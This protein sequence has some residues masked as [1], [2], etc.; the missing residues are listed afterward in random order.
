MQARPYCALVFNDTLNFGLQG[1]AR[2][3][4][5]CGG[6][7]GQFLSRFPS[8]YVQSV[9]R[10]NGLLFYNVTDYLIYKACSGYNCS[11]ASVVPDHNL[12]TDYFP[13]LLNDLSQSSP[14]SSHDFDQ[15]H[16]VHEWQSDHLSSYGTESSSTWIIPPTDYSVSSPTRGSSSGQHA[17]QNTQSSDPLLSVDNSWSSSSNSQISLM[18]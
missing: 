5:W 15:L 1:S 6:E 10:G 9:F 11:P 12:I 7:D 4:W 14:D 17:T 8:L 13:E 3:R 2:T 18:N 16:H